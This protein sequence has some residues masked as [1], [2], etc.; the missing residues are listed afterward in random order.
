MTAGEAMFPSASSERRQPIVWQVLGGDAVEAAPPFLQPAVQYGLD[1]TLLRKALRNLSK[2]IFSAEKDCKD[3]DL[4]DQF[5]DFKIVDEAFIR[6]VADVTLKLRVHGPTIG[7]GC[8]S[9][10]IRKRITDALTGAL[11]RDGLGI[12][13]FLVSPNQV[14]ADGCD[15]ANHRSSAADDITSRHSICAAYCSEEVVCGVFQW[16]K[17][18]TPTL[19]D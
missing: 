17:W 11:S 15:V 13:K 3:F 12:T 18:A 14:S 2:M 8:E 1:V 6:H 16:D 5:I 9:L 4:I 19:I 7:I 10:H